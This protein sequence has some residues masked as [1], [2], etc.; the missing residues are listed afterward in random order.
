MTR[1][2]ILGGTGDLGHGLALRLC[3]AGHDVVLGSRSAARGQEVA[4]RLGLANARGAANADAAREADVVIVACPHEGH[5]ALVRDL[6]P[7]LADKVVV[8]A[9][10]PL[11]AGLTYAPPPDGSCAQETQRLAPRARV[12]AAFHSVSA[13]LLA[14]V[15][16]PLDQDVL[17]CGDDDGAKAVVM[18]I[19]ASVGARGVDAGGLRWAPTLEALAVLVINL[20]VRY[21]RRHLGIRIAH[22]PPGARP[23]PRLAGPAP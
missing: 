9:V 23:R 5:A 20:N 11:G 13:R 15:G 1:V 12:V 6:A 22:L 4:A 14:E 8:D 7:L 19:I 17:V 3:A 18:D 16:R 21:G 10:V 2:G